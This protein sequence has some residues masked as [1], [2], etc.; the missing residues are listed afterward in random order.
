MFGASSTRFSTENF[1]K[2]LGL[3]S[4]IAGALSLLQTP[5]MSIALD[6]CGGNFRWV[7]LGL[8]CSGLPL[9]IVP[10]F[11]N[12][13]FLGTYVPPTIYDKV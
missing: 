8:L 10:V 1:G 4:A 13:Y 7:N 9:L 3:V 2:L 11:L 12:R 5:L 6:T